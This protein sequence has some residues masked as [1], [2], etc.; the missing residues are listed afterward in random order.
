VSEI[1]GILRRIQ[2]VIIINV[3]SLHVKY[4]LFLSDFKQTWNFSTDF[5]SFLN[6]KFYENSSSRCR[7]VYVDRQTDGQTDKTKLIVPF[8]NFADAPKTQQ[9]IL[10][11]GRHP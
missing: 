1:F 7:V 10:F 11:L 9:N 5:Q 3:Y 6:I 8:S 4:P 2:R